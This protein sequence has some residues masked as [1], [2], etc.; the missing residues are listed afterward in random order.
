M[1]ALS[2][3]LLVFSFV[4][5]LAPA[6]RAFSGDNSPPPRSDA[7]QKSLANWVPA[8]VGLCLEIDNLAE[9]WKQFL[10]SPMHQR[11]RRFPPLADALERHREDLARLGAEIRRRTGAGPREIGQKLLG[12][13]VL[14]AI[15][16]PQNPAIQKP[17]ALLLI[18]SADE[19]F[20]RRTLDNLVAARRQAG[21]WKGKHTLPLAG[22]PV[23]VDVVLPDDEQSEFFIASLGSIAAVSTSES[24]LRLVLDRHAAKDGSSLAASPSYRAAGERLAKQCVA[25]LW[26]NPR[27][28]EAILA[29]DLGRKPPGSEEA[30]TQASLF[31]VWRATQYVAAGVQIAPR[32]SIEL[33]SQWNAESLPEA[34]RDVVSSVA[35]PSQFP[36]KIPAE[37]LLAVAGHIDLGRLTRSVIAR[38]WQ[39]AAKSSLSEPNK[40]HERVL[41]WAL[42]AGL[43]PDW[44]LWIASGA[45]SPATLSE[46]QSLPFDVVAGI[47]TRPI[48]PGRVRP[49]LADN[50]EP[51]LNALLSATVEAANRESGK[52]IASLKSTERDGRRTTSVSG[53]VPG[54][55]Q[56]ELAYGVDQRHWFWLGTSF[57]AIEQAGD[58]QASDSLWKQ[59]ASQQHP[60]SASPPNALVYVDLAGWRK[61]ASRGRP[62]FDFLWNDRRKDDKQKDDQFQSWLT[63]TQLADRLLVVC[64]LDESSMHMA[65][66][67][68]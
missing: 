51:L 3:R 6:S 12:K 39:A 31:A 50:I 26:I 35:G 42:S 9:H 34:A 10:D 55:P 54:R 61:L 62:A 25:R 46:T 63:W 36:N 28:W 65:L 67:L 60:A 16:P 44:G 59:L 8:D 5:L 7:T 33:A 21:R 20:M 57:T 37:S 29:A 47:E 41:L 1:I 2:K 17:S 4:A 56:Q 32:L 43:G 27:A 53:M 19:Q 18:D 49:A 58:N 30:R 22:G 23:S 45:E 38:Q 40:H 66:G 13:K 64:Y 48:E 24:L 11:L 68:E 15:W 52:H 14:F